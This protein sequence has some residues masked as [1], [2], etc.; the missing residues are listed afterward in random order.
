MMKKALVIIASWAPL[1]VLVA[2]CSTA[3]Q[4]S[5][6][7]TLTGPLPSD[8]TASTGGVDAVFERHCGSFDCHGNIARPLR[9]YSQNGL[10]IP[11]EAGILPGSAPTTPDEVTANYRSVIAVEPETMNLV[12]KNSGDPYSLLILKKP[13]MIENHK[14]GPVMNKGDDAEKCIS[15][16]ISGKTDKTACTNG[17]LP[18]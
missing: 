11:N 13:L 8:F 15:S 10:R 4:S 3:P 12:V 14:G 1:A 16:W 7:Y 17:A 2:A 5:D 18:P 6:R 9:I